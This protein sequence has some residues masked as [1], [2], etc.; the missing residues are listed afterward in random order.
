M[1]GIYIIGNGGHSKVVRD[2]LESQGNVV[3]GHYDD[4]SKGERVM[5][6]LNDI[7]GNGLYI[8]AIGDSKIRETCVN[9]IGISNNSYI[10]AIHPTAWISPSAQ[11]GYGCMIGPFA[12]VQADSKIGNHVIINTGSIV[13]H[14]CIIDNYCHISPHSTL[15]GGVKIGE[16]VFIGAGATVIPKICIVDDVCIGAGATVI[17][18]ISEIGTY[19]GT[20]CRKIK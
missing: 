14:D 19:V 4:T 12:C 1:K 2:I 18:N 10:N 6:N 20:P 9:R 16:R 13:E 7:E 15:C 5:G 11:I 3:I 17:K 8:C